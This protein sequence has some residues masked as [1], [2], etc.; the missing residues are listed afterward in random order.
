MI[1]MEGWLS[2]ERGSRRKLPNYTDWLRGTQEQLWCDVVTIKPALQLPWAYDAIRVMTYD[3]WACSKVWLHSAALSNGA[4]YA[5]PLFSDLEA[6]I[7]II[8]QD[9]PSVQYSLLVRPAGMMYDTR[10]FGGDHHVRLPNGRMFTFSVR[11]G[12]DGG[13]LL[14]ALAWN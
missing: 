6:A 13:Q 4:P 1:T 5:G 10:R 8:A 11:R 2:I 14:L 7:N 9:K 3:A 12:D